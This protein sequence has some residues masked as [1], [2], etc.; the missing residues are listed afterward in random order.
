MTSRSAQL[1]PGASNPVEHLVFTDGLASVSVFVET[2]S[3]TPRTERAEPGARP[4]FGSSSAFS[5]VI[6]G[7]KVTA[8][9]EV[10]PETVRFIANSLKAAPER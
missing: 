7:R 6:D 1:M 4:R 2:Q 8:L 3:S 9:G 5:T 10:P